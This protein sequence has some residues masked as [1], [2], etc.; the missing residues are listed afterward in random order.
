M[1]KR[2][3]MHPEFS[4][5]SGDT[6]ISLGITPTVAVT[7]LLSLACLFCISLAQE[8]GIDVIAWLCERK[9]YV[10][11]TIL[12]ICLL[13]IIIGVYGNSGY[14]PIAYVYENV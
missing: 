7:V 6:F 11:F 9:W 3:F 4:Q 8:K 5:V 13:I 2:T 14:T 12:F 1:L 10:Q